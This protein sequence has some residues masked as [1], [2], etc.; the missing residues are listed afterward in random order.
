[1]LLQNYAK[2]TMDGIYEQGESFKRMGNLFR[3]VSLKFLQHIKEEGLDNST[4]TGHMEST[5]ARGK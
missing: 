1:M 4:L 2:N 3:I 5:T